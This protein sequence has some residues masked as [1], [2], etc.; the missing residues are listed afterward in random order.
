[1]PTVDSMRSRLVPMHLKL[2]RAEKADKDLAS[3]V[4][5]FH[6]F[7]FTQAN[8]MLRRDWVLDTVMSKEPHVEL[9]V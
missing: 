9:I 7:A 8:L 3:I 4:Q 5:L 2:M 1:M 6:K